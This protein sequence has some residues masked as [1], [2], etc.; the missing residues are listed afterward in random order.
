MADDGEKVDGGRSNEKRQLD[1][2]GSN[3]KAQV[4]RETRLRKPH[5]H[6]FGGFIPLLDQP[7]GILVLYIY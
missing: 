7:A 5:I 1:M 2:K 4:E 3:M 6:T